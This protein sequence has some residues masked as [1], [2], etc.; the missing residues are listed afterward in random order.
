MR[1]FHKAEGVVFL[2]ICLFLV[3]L[4]QIPNTLGRDVQDVHLNVRRGVM[5]GRACASCL[6]L[7]LKTVQRKQ[8]GRGATSEIDWVK[9]KPAV[10]MAGRR[11][12]PKSHED[13]V[14]E[15][16][17]STLNPKGGRININQRENSELTQPQR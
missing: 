17:R 13:V 4:H 15:H 7:P 12:V 16:A 3:R 11:P 5:E 14:H 8:F 2:S 1:N 6:T 9:K 10:L